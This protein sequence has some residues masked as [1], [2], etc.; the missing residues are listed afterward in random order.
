[1]EDKDRL[2]ENL[3]QTLPFVALAVLLTFIMPRHGSFEYNYRKGAKW[4]YE[5]IVAPFDFPILKTEEQLQAEKERLGSEYIACYRF[6]EEDVLASI[7]EKAIDDVEEHLQPFAMK[8]VSMLSDAYGKGVLPDETASVDISATRNHD[9]V[10][11]QKNKRSQKVPRSE[12][13]TVQSLRN[14]I[15][16]LMKSRGGYADAS[17][18]DSLLRHTGLLDILRPNLVFDAQTTEIMHQESSKFISPT[19]GVFNSGDIIVSAGETVTADIEQILDSYKVEY[20]TNI[21]Y[22]GPKYLLWLGNFFSAV[23]LAGLL[24]ALLLLNRKYFDRSRTNEKLFIITIFFISC[25]V[26]SLLSKLPAE[27]RILI[28]YPAL[29]LYGIAFLNKRLVSSLYTLSLLPLLFFCDSGSKLFVTFLASG[30]TALLAFCRFNKGWRQF[31]TALCIFGAQLFV[32]ITFRLLEGTYGSTSYRDILFLFYGSVLCIL[33]YPL[34]YL[35]EIIFNLVSVSR[36]VELSDTNNKLLRELADKAPGTFQHSLAVMNMSEAVGR[37]VDANIH[38]LR[39]AALYHDIGKINNPQCFVENQTPGVEHHKDLTPKESAREIISHVT[40]GVELAEKENIPYIVRR[41]IACHHGTTSTG[42]FHTKYLN[43]GGNPDDVADFFYPGPKPYY[44]EE[45]ILMVC[46][47][48]EAASRTLKS[49]NSK[50]VSD[51]VEKI[52]EDKKSQGQFDEADVT[53]GEI[54]KMKNVLGNYI[55]SVHHARIVYPKKKENNKY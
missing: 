27:Y 32:F 29:A 2:H 1:M 37:A 40:G 12:L 25:L 41:C 46:D 33:V 9:V 24:F 13:Y 49:F 52:F 11:L 6:A 20:E 17:S 4:D 45:L 43:E 22:S 55:V 26:C 34:T 38:L 14:R 47:A 5:T 30:I 21:G 23:I 51:L 10:F 7:E 15:P 28:P 19:S 53:L 50:E 44:K 35:F 31:I 3:K 48:I 8:F 16:G 39:T 36:L 42:Y 54:D 18:V